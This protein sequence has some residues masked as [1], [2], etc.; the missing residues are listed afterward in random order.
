MLYHGAD[1]KDNIYQIGYVLLDKDN[2]LKILERSDT[3]LISPELEWEKQGEVNNVIFG[4]G[5][6][7]LN[8]NTLRFYYA[9]ADK[10]TGYADLILDAEILE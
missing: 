3:P 7:P 6:I 9:G 4:C 8:K 1:K 2:P 5:L 10:Y